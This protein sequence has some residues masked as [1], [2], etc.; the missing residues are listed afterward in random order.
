MKSYYSKSKKETIKNKKKGKQFKPSKKGIAFSTFIRAAIGIAYVPL[1]KIEMAYGILEELALE[2]RGKKLRKFGQDFLSY[3]RK[4][5][6]NGYDRESWN[7]HM[8]RGISSNNVS[9]GYN[10]KINSRKQVG[11][12][13]NPYLLASFLKDEL[14]LAELNTECSDIGESHSRPQD[15]KF[16]RLRKFKDSMVLNMDELHGDWRTYIIAIGESTIDLDLRI[17]E[18]SDDFDPEA[19]DEFEDVDDVQLNVKVVKPLAGDELR[20]ARAKNA[21]KRV[22]FNK[23]LNA[24]YYN[25]SIEQA[26]DNQEIPVES[27]DEQVEDSYQ[28][29][30]S[31]DLDFTLTVKP[32]KKAKDHKKPADIPV[33]TVKPPKKSKA[34]KKPVKEAQSKPLLSLAEGKVLQLNRLRD[35]NFEV[36]PSQ[37]DTVGDGNCFVYS[38]LDQLR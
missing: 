31:Q 38:I 10:S 15:A 1:N 24:S 4:T 19:K 30:G 35:I 13:P 17:A 28:K 2:L 18:T 11:F 5:W 21:K 29:N 37:P 22:S 33:K 36:S 27:V 9:E 12:N 23:T 32:T 8:H 7:M 34:P 6:L 3:Y 14:A 26:I 20:K 25:D 16:K